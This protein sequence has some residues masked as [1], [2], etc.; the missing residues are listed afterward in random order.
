M[1]SIERTAYPFFKRNPSASE[2]AQIYTPTDDEIAWAIRQVREPARRLSFLLLLKGF[3]RLGYF[4]ALEAVPIAIM[5]QVRD[6]LRLSGHARPATLG[7][8]TLYRYHATIRQR[9][10]VSAF[11]ERGMHAATRA[12]GI[13]A[14][15]MDNPADLIN[16]AIEQLIKDKIELPA[17]STLDRLARRVRALVNQRLFSLV[18]Q[19]L[20][21]EEAAQ[22][23]T[24]LDVDTGRRQSPL[25]LI[26]QLPKRSSLQH[27]QRLIEHIAR[28]SNL[29]G[30]MHLLA[31]V[32]EVKIKHFAAEAKALDAAELRDFGAPKRHMLLLSLIHRARIQARDDLAAMYIKRMNNL[33]RRAKEEMERLRVRHREKTEAIVATLADVP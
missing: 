24:L 13:A 32:P 4:P 19:R 9:L 1:A 3:Q 29:M 26:K 14:G 28:L 31:D 10:D 27:F 15:V 33:H 2:L 17:F 23:D 18:Q 16:A 7:A 22:L 30:D 11:R 6:T 12:V 5:R 8:R 25:Q 21:T 20:T